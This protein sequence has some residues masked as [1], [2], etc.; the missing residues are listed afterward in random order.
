MEHKP[1]LRE[2]MYRIVSSGPQLGLVR[3]LQ[4]AE[5]S[6]LDNHPEPIK[7]ID[8]N[9]VEGNTYR[10]TPSAW[11]QGGYQPST[12][13]GPA[14]PEVD[15]AWGDDPPDDSGDWNPLFRAPQEEPDRH[16]LMVMLVRRATL[17]D[18]WRAF[19]DGFHWLNGARSELTR[20]RQVKP[21]VFATPTA[22]WGKIVVDWAE[23]HAVKA[24]ASP[25]PRPFFKPGQ[26]GQHGFSGWP[27]PKTPPEMLRDTIEPAWS[28][29]PDSLVLGQVASV[30]PPKQYSY[31]DAA[32]K[33][34]GPDGQTIVDLGEGS[35][36][37]ALFDYDPNK[38]GPG[39][40]RAEVVADKPGWLTHQGLVV[41]TPPMAGGLFNPSTFVPL[42]VSAAEAEAAKKYFGTVVAC[43]AGVELTVKDGC[44]LYAPDGSVAGTVDCVRWEDG[45]LVAQMTVS[46]QNQHWLEDKPGVSV[47]FVPPSAV[48]VS[49]DPSPYKPHVS[50][51]PQRMVDQLGRPPQLGDWYSCC[52]DNMEEVWNA[53]RLAEIFSQQVDGDSGGC[54]GLTKAHLRAMIIGH[55]YT[56]TDTGEVCPDTGPAAQPPG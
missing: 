53:T 19:W 20:Y 37:G 23:D 3:V 45:R 30:A 42:V 13:D 14:E 46:P 11:Y 25:L 39:Q 21:V 54:W 51:W 41:D 15:V 47:G 27:D 48:F 10:F 32:A 33:I 50:G 40:P 24:G 31:V 7:L 5:Q 56:D 2:V 22:D 1:T 44:P 9:R 4:L 8:W 38:E 35:V 52:L 49:L 26:W 17:L 6:L 16:A 34:V 18:K 29:R 12:P 55:D 43:P 36:V 28:N